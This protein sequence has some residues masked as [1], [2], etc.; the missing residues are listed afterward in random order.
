MGK[1]HTCYNC[2]K[3]LEEGKQTFWKI[4]LTETKT[5]TNM[6]DEQAFC[7]RECIHYGLPLLSTIP[8]VNCNKEIS[9]ST[10]NCISGKKYCKDCYLA[11][12]AANGVQNGI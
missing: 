11:Y 2:H 7:S 6:F 5:S 9:P 3:I 4:S 8:C 1:K 10:S 12:L